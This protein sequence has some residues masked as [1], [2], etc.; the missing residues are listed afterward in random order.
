MVDLMGKLPLI[1]HFIGEAT[2]AVFSDLIKAE[3]LIENSD[4]RF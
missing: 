1:L 3:E 4:R 2:E